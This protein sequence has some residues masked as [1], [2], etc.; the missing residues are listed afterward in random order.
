MGSTVKL[1]TGVVRDQVRGLATMVFYVME[2]MIFAVPFYLVA[3][4]KLIIPVPSWRLFWSKVLR[5]VVDIWMY[6]LNFPQCLNRKTRWVIRGWEDMSRVNL[7][8]S[9]MLMVNHQTWVDIMVLVK[10]FYRNIPEFKFFAKKE[11]LWIPLIGLAMVAADYPMVKRYKK[12]FL[13]KHPHLAGKDL[14]LTRKACEKFKNM[15][16]SVFSFVEGTRFREEK[17]RKQHSPFTHLLKPKAGG[18]SLVLGAM[19]DKIQNILNVTIV[20]PE[21]VKNFWEYL[22]GKVEE[23][24]V[25]VEVLPVSRDLIGDY[26]NDAQYRQ[27]FHLWINDLW[28]EKDRLIDE[29]LQWEQTRPVEVS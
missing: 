22:C 1:M 7:C 26:F 3:F 15:P 2:T 14:E 20:Y 6:F 13:E 18:V 21:G 8:K 9:C 11:L 16:V 25:H 19:G 24:R 4:V 17:H 10:L 5:R 23:I 28:L 29:M 12:A 27:R